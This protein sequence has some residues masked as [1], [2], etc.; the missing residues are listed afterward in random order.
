M[1][2]SEAVNPT[3]LAPIFTALAPG[4][5]VTV[6]HSGAADDTDAL[7][8]KI[9]AEL[10]IAGFSDLAIEGT[11]VVGKR[12]SSGAANGSEAATSA[13]LPLRMKLNGS[14]SKDAASKA[15]KK[16]LWST[17]PSSATALIDAESLLTA[18]DKINPNAVRGTDCPPAQPGFNAAGGVKR[19]KACKGCTCGLRELQEAENAGD[20]EIVQLDADDMNSDLPTAKVAKGEDGGGMVRREIIETVMGADG[21]EKKVKRVHVETKG[22]TSSCGSCFLGDAFRCSSCPYLGESWRAQINRTS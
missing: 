18:A 13:A 8:K 5:S 6:A 11:K 4:S 19:K 15:A 21:K 1:P 14:G 3:L 17:Q 7:A 2:F 12:S 22:A 16:A 9:K 10:L 20:T